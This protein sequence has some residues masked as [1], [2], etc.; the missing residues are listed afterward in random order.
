MAASWQAR[1]AYEGNLSPIAKQRLKDRRRTA[2]QT[3]IAAPKYRVIYLA[4]GRER[5][6]PWLYK[7]ELANKA[8]GMMQSKYGPRSAI[9]FVD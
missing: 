2:T 6:S 7:Q 5:L 8:L 4:N 9:I 1:I 3:P